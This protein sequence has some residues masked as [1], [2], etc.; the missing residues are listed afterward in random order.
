MKIISQ[1][2]V[3]CA[4][5]F[6]FSFASVVQADTNALQGETDQLKASVKAAEEWLN[7]I[8]REKYEESWDTGSI[9]F[10][11]TVPKN[12]WVMLMDQIRKPLGDV[13]SRKIL[14]Q[15]TAKD[16]KGLPKGDYM[17][18]FFD[19]SF[20]KKEVAHELVTL[21]QTSDGTWKILTYQVQ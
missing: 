20:S 4:F 7:L 10:Q 17:V 11:L 2:C 14:D 16:P 6:L 12:H 3:F 15:R 13:S 18:I 8:D 19:T 9:N 5:V 1:L 21:I